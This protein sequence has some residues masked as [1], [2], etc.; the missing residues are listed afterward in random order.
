MKRDLIR[1][2]IHGRVFKLAE[3]MP[4]AARLVSENH[5]VAVPGFA[6]LI[7]CQAGT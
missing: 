3:W 7:V 2:V 6:I 4:V 5:P 1:R